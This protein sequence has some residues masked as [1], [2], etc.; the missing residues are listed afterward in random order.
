MST[1]QI[2]AISLPSILL[3]KISAEAKNDHTSRSEIIRRS[4]KQHFFMRDFSAARNQTLAELDKKG[5][6]LTEENVFEQI[7]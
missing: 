2:V 3:K 1:R 4:L 6:H 5:V 7:S